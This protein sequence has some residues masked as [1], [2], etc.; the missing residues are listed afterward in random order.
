MKN[1]FIVLAI[2]IV[3]ACKG[4]QPDVEETSSFPIA[5]TPSKTIL[6]QDSCYCF[7][8]VTWK[9]NTSVIDAEYKLKAFKNKK[10]AVV[11]CE[12]RKDLVKML[13]FIK[14]K[15]R[16]PKEPLLPIAGAVAGPVS[17]YLYRRDQSK[18]Y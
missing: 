10:A 2:I 16:G 11:W 17:F 15:I 9:S 13:N 7:I 12:Y 8:E 14:S 3:G 1:L 5:E 4:P 6:S 18:D